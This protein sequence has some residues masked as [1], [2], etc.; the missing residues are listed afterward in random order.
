MDR[1]KELVHIDMGFWITR[2]EVDTPYF[3]HDS[4]TYNLPDGVMQHYIELSSVSESAVYI[5]KFLLENLNKAFDVLDIIDK[6]IYYK[7]DLYLLHCK[8]YD[9][10]NSVV[11]M[12][13][14]NNTGIVNTFS[15]GRGVN[16]QNFTFEEKKIIQF[17]VPNLVESLRINL[18]SSLS[19]NK[20]KTLCLRGVVDKH[21]HII[22]SEERFTHLAIELEV[23]YNNKIDTEK[24]QNPAFKK[25]KNILI[26]ITNYD[27][28]YYIEVETLPIWDSLSKRKIQICDLLCKGLSNKEIARKLFISQNSVNSHLKDINKLLNVSSRYQAIALLSEYKWH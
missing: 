1:L 27:G 19:K 26:N 20:D 15:F 22:E 21:G 7:S 23:L 11:M 8:K 6:D 24:I 16:H 14:N 25:E 3:D 5:T 12:M 18:I 17:V 28:L 9:I 4:F 2:S 10:E 13:V